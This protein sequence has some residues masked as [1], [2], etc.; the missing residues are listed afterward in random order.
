M[1]IIPDLCSI[2][3]AGRIPEAVCA[4]CGFRNASGHHRPEHRGFAR[5]VDPTG[6]VYLCTC[7]AMVAVIAAGEQ[8]EFEVTLLLDVP[9]VEVA[10]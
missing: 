9:A 10:A 6:A 2:C 8:G 7:C 1:H 5:A 4:A 3:A